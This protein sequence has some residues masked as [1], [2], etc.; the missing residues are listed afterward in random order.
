MTNRIWLCL[1]ILA[2]VLAYGAHHKVQRVTAPV[3]S[4]VLFK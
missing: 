3:Q 1:A 4:G 2:V